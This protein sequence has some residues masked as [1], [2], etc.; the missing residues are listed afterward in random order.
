MLSCNGL[1]EGFRLNGMLD[2]G[3]I[4]RGLEM[5]GF[6][7]ALRRLEM[8]ALVDALDIDRRP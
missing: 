2:A 5:L 3:M 4:G 6:D 8:L 1:N 7:C